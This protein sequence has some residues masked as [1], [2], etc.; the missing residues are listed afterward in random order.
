MNQP[1]YQKQDQKTHDELQRAVKL[2]KQ[3]SLTEAENVYRNILARRPTHFDAQHLLGLV[4]M[5]AGNPAQAAVEIGLALE[6]DATSWMA[7]N[8]QGNAYRQM[9]DYTAALAAYDAALV[10][11]PN[12]IEAMV[13]KG[14]VLRDTGNTE[15]ALENFN[16]ALAIDP[17]QLEALVNKAQALQTLG[18]HDDARAVIDDAVKQYPARADLKKVADTFAQGGAAELWTRALELR[19]IEDH[20]GALLLLRQILTLEPEDAAAHAQ[21]GYVL[22]QMGDSATA[23]AH[24]DKSLQIQPDQSDVYMNMGMVLRSLRRYPEAIAS[25][26]RAIGLKPDHAPSYLNLANVMVDLNK[27]NEALE[28]IDRGVALAPEEPAMWNNRGMILR[29]MKRLVESLE[30]YDRVAALDPDHDFV[31]GLRHHINMQLCQWQMLP[32]VLDM[33]KKIEDGI[34]VSM[35]FPLV[36]LPV[37]AADQKTAAALYTAKKYPPRKALWQGEKYGHDKIRIAY[38]SADFHRHAT[39][40]LMAGMF[41]CHDRSAFEIVAIS[42][43]RNDNSDMRKRLEATFD[44]FI[45][46]STKT[47][48]EIASLL[49]ALEIDIAVDLKG[50][51]QDSRPAILSGRVAP[52]QV[53]YLGFPGTLA[54]PYIDYIIADDVVLPESLYP[55]FSEKVVALPESYQVNDNKRAISKT[56]PTRAECGLPE[57]AFVFCAFNNSYKITPEFFDIWMRLLKG[58]DGSVL[59]LLDSGDVTTANLRREAQARGIDSTRLVFAKRAVLEDHLARHCHADLFLD[60]LPCNAH[61]TA[62]D[63]LWADVP[64]LTC[65]GDTFAGRVAGSLLHAVGLPE[66]VTENVQT[67]EALALDL[68]THPEKLAAVRQKLQAR[69]ATAPLFDTPRFTKHIEAAFTQMH[70]RATED[71]PPQ[72]FKVAPVS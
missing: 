2:H 48:A 3:G 40:Y 26:I 17:A 6:I 47:D 59:W 46:V 10:Q 7:H 38:L 61:T 41:E 55:H 62:S 16:A 71:T 54:A 70:K 1:S 33:M 42:F 67:Y 25:F 13:N 27:Y 19:R 8:N 4:L 21:M 66:L 60:N 44:Q 18:R 5:Q 45:D 9:K 50:F 57:G 20:A 39:S 31:M 32:Q 64:V 36:A 22:Q 63:A 11:K 29:E 49:Y 15:A 24:Y 58:V 23:L 51:T 56:P 72:S 37:S 68:A 34:L 14:N 28:S 43:G 12:C 53:S 52:V 65:L 30:S 35:P 69:K